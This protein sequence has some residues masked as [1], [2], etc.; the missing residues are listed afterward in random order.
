MHMTR[1]KVVATMGPAVSKTDTLFELFKVGDRVLIED[2][3]YRFVCIE[4]NFNELR[5]SCTVGG[6]LKSGKG[7]NLPNTIVNVPSL[8]DRDWECVG[9]AIENGLDYLALSFVRKPDDI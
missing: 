5:C 2:G 1:T 8:T 3:M 4:K 7:I 6:V 9:W